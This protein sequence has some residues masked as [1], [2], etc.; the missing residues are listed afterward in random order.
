VRSGIVKGDVVPVVISVA[1]Q[2]SPNSPAVTM[3]VQ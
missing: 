2:T 1:G 3:A